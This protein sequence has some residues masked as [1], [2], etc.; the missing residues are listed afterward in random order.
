MKSRFSSEPQRHDAPPVTGVLITNLGSPDAPTPTAVRRYL[1]EFLADPRIVELPRWL[2]WLILHGIILRVRP[3][4]SARAYAKIWTAQGSPLLE[5]SRQQQAA[6]QQA[7]QARWP[8]PIQVV[9]GMRYGQ[10]SIATALAELRAAGARRVLVLPL[11]PQYASAT[12]GS[13]FDAVA[14]VLQGWRWLPDLRF[15]SHYHDDAGYIR[16][17]AEHIQTYWAA[18]GRPD[19]LLFSF[20]GIP[21]RTFLAG[22]PYHC[23]CHKTARLVAEQLG[24]A[25]DNWQVCFQSRFGRE[26]WLQPYTDHTLQAL[27]AAGMRRVDVVCPGFSADC[28]ETLEEIDEQNRALFLQAGGQAFHYIPALNAH[29][30]HIALLSDLIAR[31]LQGWS[32]ADL[33]TVQAAADLSLQRARALGA[34]Q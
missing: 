34:E 24:L 10:P 25:A 3:A 16:V 15:I 28:L 12:T 8:G 22:D 17:L 9:L 33:P 5:I 19:K 7:L 27:G 21:Q 13:T 14:A 2:W 26:A 31:E 30:D 32:T 1:A 4:R 11:Y 29:P 20:H 6:L 23:E 18:Q